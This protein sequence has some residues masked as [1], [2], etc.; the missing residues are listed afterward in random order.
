MN[1]S[2][3][4]KEQARLRSACSTCDTWSEVVEQFPGMTYRQV[5]SMASNMGLR[6]PP[7]SSKDKWTAEEEETLERMWNEPCSIAEILDAVG[8]TRGS[9]YN[10]VQMMRRSGV[11][12]KDKRE[13]FQGLMRAGK[14]DFMGMMG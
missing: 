13:R 6:T 11:P 3:T 4:T 9:V 14:I 10:K 1:H 12:L 7:G 5:T 8:H 2:W